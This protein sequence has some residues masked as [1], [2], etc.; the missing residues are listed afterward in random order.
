MNALVHHFGLNV[1]QWPDSSHGCNRDFMLALQ[2]C[3]LKKFWL[4]MV[5][6]F[7]VPFGP[8]RDDYR[9][10]QIRST[11]KAYFRSHDITTAYLFQQMCPAILEEH[12]KAGITYPG[13]MSAEQE[14]W[15]MLSSRSHFAKVGRRV[16]LNRFL[17]SVEAAEFNLGYWT[18]DLFE[19][20]LVCLEMGF[21]K[22]AKFMHKFGLVAGDSEE[23]PE[24]VRPLA[25]RSLWRL[26][27]S[28]EKLVY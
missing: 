23:V 13:E 9:Y 12:H 20:T 26:A 28:V 4:C 14:C 16:N 7:K 6:S 5:V 8:D 17:G 24:G 2:G 21:L 25:R 3:S 1:W 15:D 10:H 27:Q 19:R 11:V 22:G 18:T